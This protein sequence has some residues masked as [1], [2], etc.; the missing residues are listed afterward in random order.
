MPSSGKASFIVAASASAPSTGRITGRIAMWY[1]LAEFEV[2]LIV[3]GHGH[4]GAGAVAHQ[5]EVA[6]PDGN[7]LAAERVDGE[8]AGGEAFLLDV[9]GAFGGARVDHVFHLRP[10][11]SSSDLGDQRMLGREDH[12]RR[13]IDGVDARGED[14]D[15][16]AGPFEMKIDLR[17]FRAADPVA[18]HEQHAL[19]PS[20]FELAHGARAVRR[21]SW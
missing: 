8:V 14:A 2:A 15:G 4:D 16:R 11:A 13:A 9:A 7:L 19:R 1:L 17:A 5:D 3:R 21:R 12:A 6:D 10:V 20:G 18:L